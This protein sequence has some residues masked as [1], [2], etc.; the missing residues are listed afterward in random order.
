MNTPLL[1]G[2]A[3]ILLLW[4]IFTYNSFIS[5]VNQVTNAWADIDVQLKRRADLI[6]N[7]IEVVKGYAKHEKDVFENVAKARSALMETSRPG[8]KA[9][10]NTMLTSALKSLFA[11]AENYPKLMASDNFSKLQEE[12]ATTE[13]NIEASRRYYNAT[14]RDLNT[15]LQT[16]PNNILA[17]IFHVEKREFFEANE[18]DKKSVS[19]SMK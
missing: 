6:P 18:E 9:E 13:N 12:L 17:N 7:L 5:L 15:K 2:I 1:I 11:I 8:E 4:I 10:A 19:V 3:I 14:V 16:F